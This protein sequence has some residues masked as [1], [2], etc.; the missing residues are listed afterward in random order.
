MYR[1]HSLPDAGPVVLFRGGG[2]RTLD[3][4]LEAPQQEIEN[5]IS[6]E[7][8]RQ[9]MPLCDGF[10]SEE[11]TVMMKVVPFFEEMG[12]NQRPR[13]WGWVF[14]SNTLFLKS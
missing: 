3:V 5:V 8:I 12:G 14:C 2:V 13:S 4:L 6:D 7:V 10:C 9:V 11:L 1:I